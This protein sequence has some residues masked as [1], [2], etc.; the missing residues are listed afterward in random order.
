ML[1]YLKRRFLEFLI[2][3]KLLSEMPNDNP[4]KMLLKRI[5]LNP[6]CII[7]NCFVLYLL[8]RVLI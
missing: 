3:I 7:W 6:Y 1:K 4:Y 5:I 8:Y 2:I